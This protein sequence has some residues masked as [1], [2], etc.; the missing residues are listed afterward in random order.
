MKLS[1]I[2]KALYSLFSR[3]EKKTYRFISLFLLS[4]TSVLILSCSQKAIPELSY[5]TNSI[6]N[7]VPTPSSPKLASSK[8][9]PLPYSRPISSNK[10]LNNF[11]NQGCEKTITTGDVNPEDF[12]KSAIKYLGT[13]HRMGGTS[14]NG[15]DCS[16]LVM[17][18]FSDNKI[19]IAHN[20]E[21]QARYGKVVLE[22]NNLR[23]GDLVFFINT[24]R[25]SKYITHV[26][27]YLGNYQMIHASSSKGVSITSLN[28]S[29][30]K[31]KFIFGTRLFD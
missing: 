20:A 31:D 8:T 2:S 7:N 1:N 9:L 23:K 21:D 17:R 6:I 30:W 28:N 10:G 26:G 5:S 14:Q 25:T 22:K 27:I 4:I 11:F 16:G 13:P 18:A 15:I 19:K 29:W 3:F 24:Y 12:L